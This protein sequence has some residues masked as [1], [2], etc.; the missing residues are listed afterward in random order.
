M[1][2][3]VKDELNRC[4]IFLQDVFMLDYY[5]IKTFF[6]VCGTTKETVFLIELAVRE[7]EQGVMIRVPM[8]PSRKPRVILRDNTPT[9]S[10]YEVTPAKLNGK[11]YWLPIRIDPGDPLNSE[12]KRYE[13][14][15]IC[16]YAYAIPIKDVLNKY[17]EKPKDNRK[18]KANWA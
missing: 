4:G 13:S 15:P 10:R 12:A 5:G 17:W 14:D 8:K 3:A 7:T 6:Q 2:E 16:G 9:K 11:D 18:P 1:G